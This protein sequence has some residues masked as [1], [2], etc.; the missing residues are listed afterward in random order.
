MTQIIV[1]MN[2]LEATDYDEARYDEIK[3][4][5]LPFLIKQGFKKAD[6]MF[7][8]ISGLKGENLIEKSTDPNLV[9]WYGADSPSLVDILDGLRLPERKFV[10]PLRASV[11]AYF[12]AATGNLIGD[13]FKVK[14]ETGVLKSSKEP[15]LLMP[16]NVQVQIK[17][18][19]SEDEEEIPYAL[20]GTICTVGVKLPADYDTNHEQKGAVFCDPQYPI[21]YVRTFVC[22][23]VV[24]EIPKELN[25]GKISKGEKV[26][27]HSYTNYSAGQCKSLLSTVDQKTGEPI[28]QKP[29]F[30]VPGMFA[31]IKI[32]LDERRC[33][34]LFSNFPAMGRIVLRTGSYTIAAGRIISFVN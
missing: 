31:D 20:A 1:A 29:K 11:S 32:R 13:C 18:M 34:E 30:L 17:G 9:K 5:V 8:P 7:V 23:V 12:K 21:K 25:G 22:R 27:I 6:I 26:T 15:I 16:E 14:V 28:K 24:Y 4:Q 10:R 19:L 3:E 33:L 2:K